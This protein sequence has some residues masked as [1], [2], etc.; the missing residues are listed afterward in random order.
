MNNSLISLL[1]IVFSVIGVWTDVLGQSIQKQK[2]KSYLPFSQS[3]INDFAEHIQLECKYGNGSVK[4]IIA[5]HYIRK[6]PPLTLPEVAI[7]I[8]NLRNNINDVIEMLEAIKMAT[9]GNSKQ[10]HDRDF[11]FNNLLSLNISA[12]DSKILTDYIFN[13]DGKY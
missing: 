8:E 6:N 4:T 3:T 5:L 1:I 2:P 11:L 12:T 9:I 7:K 13:I 10:P